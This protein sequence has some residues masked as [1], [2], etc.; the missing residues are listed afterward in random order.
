MS[1]INLRY[2]NVDPNERTL[3]REDILQQKK[4][5]LLQKPK[6]PRKFLYGYT[7]GEEEFDFFHEWIVEEG[8]EAFYEGLS[9]E[10]F[11]QEM[12]LEGLREYF[13]R[14]LMRNYDIY[15]HNY[16]ALKR[17]KIEY[18][19]KNGFYEIDNN[20]VELPPLLAKSFSPIKT[21][22]SDEDREESAEYEVRMS[23]L[24][25]TIEMLLTYFGDDGIKATLR[26]KTNEND[27]IDFFVKMPDGRQ[28]AIVL[29]S[30]GNAFLKWR[31]DKRSFYVYKKG[32]KGMNKWD[33]MNSAID[34]LKS[35]I[36]L[37]KQK[38]PLL[39]LTRS[40]QNRPINKV[41][42]LCDGTK[43]ATNNLP[44]Y[45]TD[46]GL[47]KALR[48]YKDS[49]TYVVEQDNLIDFLQLPVKGS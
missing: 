37:K 38:S 35:T 20:R 32:R 23:R 49:L 13:L 43:I 5:F 31:E 44:E 36:D 17:L 27:I 2:E 21:S 34:K 30:N 29:R 45:W 48:I 11:D 24:I 4:E 1:D 6:Y 33:S 26:V 22:Y 47:T 41:I 19:A 39:G 46:F 14:I 3:S 8:Y 42:V 25:S 16:D 12:Y 18:N 28:F 9:Q 15:S 40:E 7:P 10:E